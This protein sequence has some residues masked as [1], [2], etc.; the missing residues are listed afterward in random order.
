MELHKTRL[1]KLYSIIIF[2]FFHGSKITG[3]RER[4]KH[5]YEMYSR[6]TAADYHNT[7]VNLK[8]QYVVAARMWCFEQSRGYVHKQ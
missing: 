1:M 3:L 4:T 2:I 5:V 7:L 8:V 6:H